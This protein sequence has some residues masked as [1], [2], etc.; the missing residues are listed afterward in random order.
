MP[1]ASVEVEQLRRAWAEAVVLGGVTRRA[2]PRPALP[3]WFGEN[4]PGIDSCEGQIEGAHWIKRQR[5]GK[6]GSQI[7]NWKTVGEGEGEFCWH[8]DP[9]IL[10]A[11][12]WDPRNGVPACNKHHTRF[13][14][15]R[16]PSLVVVR[17]HVPAA[18]EAFA[19]DWGLEPELARKC[20]TMGEGI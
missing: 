5:I 4:I 9:F 3:C 18:V 17:E 10:W 12:E 1:R 20:P 11:A 15:Q 6:H 14:G 13:D 7:G 2:S 16:M 8:W 19:R